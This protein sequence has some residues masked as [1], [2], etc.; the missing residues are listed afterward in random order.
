MM[1]C[2]DGSKHGKSYSVWRPAQELEPVWRDA[3]KAD[4][5][6]HKRRFYRYQLEPCGHVVERGQPRRTHCYCEHCY[7]RDTGIITERLGA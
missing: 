5:T 3:R 4:G 6:P 2:A 7:E 1:A